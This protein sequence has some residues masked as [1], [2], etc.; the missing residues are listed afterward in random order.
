MSLF[1]F[2]EYWETGTFVFFWILGA[3]IAILCQKG[4]K[5]NLISKKK[6]NGYYFFAFFLLWFFYAFKHE[7]VGTDTKNYLYQFER[8]MNEEVRFDRILTFKQI[9]PFYIWFIQII[10]S[11]TDSYTVLFSFSGAIISYGYIK[12]IMTFFDENSN[13]IFVI[14]ITVSYF[15]ALSG[16]RYALGTAFVLCSLCALAKDKALRA[17]LLTFTGTMFHYTMIINVFVIIYY[18]VFK[19]RKNLRRKAVIIP[20]AVLSVVLSMFVG[21]LNAF[22]ADTKYGFYSDSGG[23]LIGNWYVVLAII[24]DLYILYIDKKSSKKNYLNSLVV[25]SNIP[26]LLI[27]LG[28]H[29]YRL[30]Y[31]YALPRMALWGYAM[32]T[33]I[34]FRKDYRTRTSVANEKFLLDI[35][36]LLCVVLY[37]LFRFSRYSGNAGFAYRT[38][39]F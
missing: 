13:Y 18:F 14:P 21:K 16:I 23:S 11:F 26:I 12:F 10:R 39:F 8:A 34:L 29:A 22:F 31:Y 27:V 3:V 19:Q 17:I 9:E 24:L 32:N 37:M 2:G 25:L 7:C 35:I 20:T 33:D 36:M 5:R 28:T 38:I 15:S 1:E 30:V 6:W 4:A